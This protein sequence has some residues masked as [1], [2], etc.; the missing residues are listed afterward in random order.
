MKSRNYLKLNYA[1]AESRYHSGLLT[2]RQWRTFL[3]CWTWAAPR[4]SS[5]AGLRQDAYAS[6]HGLPA[7]YARMNRVRRALGL[8]SY[9]V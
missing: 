5:P 3:F 1:Q 4:Y 2:E 9:A 8:D 7:L 6:R